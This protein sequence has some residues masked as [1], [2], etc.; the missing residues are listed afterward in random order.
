MDVKGSSRNQQTLWNLYFSESELSVDCWTPPCISENRHRDPSAAESNQAAAVS[1]ANE[2]RS[3]DGIQLCSSWCSGFWFLRRRPTLIQPVPSEPSGT[4]APRSTVSPA[5][6]PH[7]DPAQTDTASPRQ[8]PLILCKQKLLFC[9]RLIT[10]N[11]LTTL[12][13]TNNTKI[14]LV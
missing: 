13:K 1:L 5:R 4:G 6:S 11:H 8:E 10:I 7:T 2:I 9:M 3:G 14:A 12:I